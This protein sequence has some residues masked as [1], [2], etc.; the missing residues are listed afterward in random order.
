[1]GFLLPSVASGVVALL[2]FIIGLSPAICILAAAAAFPSVHLLLLEKQPKSTTNYFDEEEALAAK[3]D[4]KRQKRVEEAKRK[5]LAKVNAAVE[6]VEKPVK[7]TAAKVVAAVETESDNEDDDEEVDSK[8]LSK[9][10][11]KKAK[12]KKAEQERKRQEEEERK[13]QEEEKKK[14]EAKKKKAAKKAAK[15]G[16]ASSSSSSAATVVDDFIPVE[17]KRSPVHHEDDGWQSVRSDRSSSHKKAAAATVDQSKTAGDAK[18]GGKTGNAATYVP[19]TV[20]ELYIPAKFH[21]L[22]IGKDAS[23]LK[24]LQAG[25]GARI[26]MPKKDSGSTKVQIIGDAP[27]VANC[28]SAIHSLIT[29]G[30]SQ[31]THPGTVHDDIH[32]D[33]KNFGAVIGPKGDYL[34]S[35]QSK[36]NTRINFPEK[37]SNSER[38]TIVG[39]KDDVRAARLAIKELLADGYSPLTHE[40]L[41]KKDIDFPKD[42]VHVLVGPK[43][44][45]IKSI[46]GDT[47]TKINIKPTGVTIVGPPEGVARAERQIDKLL[48]PPTIVEED[49]EEEYVNGTWAHSQTNEDDLW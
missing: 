14:E 20:L 37:D 49:P 30:Y 13:R 31:I 15:S 1:M 6:K 21:A 19:E 7:E 10:A 25:S 2:A 35:I 32:V 3:K 29:Y 34:K 39:K 27:S 47:K 46:Q 40:G 42:K 41:I 43:G 38:V 48:T 23:T 26:E 17:T 5:A 16:A 12:K 22:L 36:T 28:N 9:S 33:T 8:K 24:V 18:K 4:A 45:T 11:A 44:Q